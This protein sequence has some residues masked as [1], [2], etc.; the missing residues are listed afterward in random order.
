MKG[1]RFQ[2]KAQQN[3]RMDLLNPHPTLSHIPN[4]R[5]RGGMMKDQ[6]YN[7]HLLLGY[8][9]YLPKVRKMGKKG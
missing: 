1:C 4:P 2:K 7:L 6:N 3:L 5:V 9:L 8:N